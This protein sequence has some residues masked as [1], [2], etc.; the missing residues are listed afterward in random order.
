MN[1]PADEIS[2]NQSYAFWSTCALA[3]VGACT[4]LV[5][6]LMKLMVT[7]VL[8]HNPGALND[9]HS[10]SWTKLL[11]SAGADINYQDPNGYTPLHRAVRE[12][13]VDIVAYLIA[14][15]GI[16]DM[17]EQTFGYTPLHLACIKD[18]MNL[19]A[20]LLDAGAKIDQQSNDGSTPLHLAVTYNAASD[21]IS[22]LLNRAAHV[23]ITDRMHKTPLFYAVEKGR[24]DAI[25]LLL[26]HSAPDLTAK[27][28]QRKS[29]LTTVMKK[30]DI[31]LCRHFI[32]RGFFSGHPSYLPH[33]A[34][35]AM[36]Q[37]IQFPTKA[38]PGIETFPEYFIYQFIDLAPMEKQKELISYWLERDEYWKVKSFLNIYLIRHVEHVRKEAS[39]LNLSDGFFHALENILNAEQTH[40]AIAENCLGIEKDI[41]KKLTK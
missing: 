13:Y 30:E 11:V 39:L 6:K 12:K 14:C 36:E 19:V 27:N 40:K 37:L 16:N 31:D 7:S 35:K 25:K 5:R 23:A 21:V 1:P 34:C 18:D 26:A 8:A 2:S 29:L 4:F 17:P 10:L 15:D 33:L 3:G 9:S 38:M 28:K 20:M 32:I 41:F 22:L 24:N